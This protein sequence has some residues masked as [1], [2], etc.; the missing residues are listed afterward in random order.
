MDLTRIAALAAALVLA[1]CGG[2]A[3]VT[4]GGDRLPAVNPSN[5]DLPPPV[6]VT[7]GD[8]GLELFAWTTCFESGCFDGAPPTRPASVG[9]PDRVELGFGLADWKWRATFREPGDRCSRHIS[10]PAE[11]TGAHTFVVRPA[12]PAGTWDVDLEGRGPEG[13]FFTTFRWTTTR[14]GDDPQ[15][16]DGTVSVLTELDGALD[17]YGVELGIENLALHPERASATVTVEDP[18]GESV[19]IPLPPPDD[20]YIEGNL[21]FSVPESKSDRAVE[22]GGN[23]PFEYTVELTLDGREYVGSGTWP[24]DEIG[25]YAPHTALDWQPPLPSYS[26]E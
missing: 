17:S 18:S 1:S 11:R 26:S 15:A 13:D 5:P 2:D 4:E 24:E 9:S 20:C 16:A 14:V 3:V 25:N 19:T 12:G 7:S 21:W 23:G 6:V 8:S 10:V 22:L